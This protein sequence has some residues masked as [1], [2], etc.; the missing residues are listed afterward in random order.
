MQLASLMP[1]ARKLVFLPGKLVILE[2]G[3]QTLAQ[4]DKVRQTLPRMNKA[5][6]DGTVASDHI[7]TLR[8]QRH[9][10]QA[11]YSFDGTGKRRRCAC[12]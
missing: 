4:V 1:V 10:D 2:V 5:F 7:P 11:G 3:T 6:A 8:A 9:L 12:P